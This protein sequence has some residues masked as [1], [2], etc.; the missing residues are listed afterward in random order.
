MKKINLVTAAK[1]L[2]KHG[3]VYLFYALKLQ[4]QERQLQILKHCKKLEI[5]AHHRCIDSLNDEINAL[6][7][8]QIRTSDDFDA[9]YWEPSMPQTVSNDEINAW[10][11]TQIRT[12]DGFD[13]RYWTASMPQTVSNASKDQP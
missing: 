10:V 6:V 11:M 1:L 5:E 3:V 4:R 13:A 12:K 9:R 8:A 7:M 2:M